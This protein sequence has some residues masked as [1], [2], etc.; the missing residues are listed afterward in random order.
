[1]NGS[2]RWRGSDGPRPH[3]TA[4][5]LVMRSPFRFG[6][7]A[8]L[9]GAVV[10]AAALLLPVLSTVLVMFLVAWLLA[11]G[12]NRGVALLVRK[13]LR[14]GL[15]V[16]AVLLGC[17]LAAALLG[18]IVVPVAVTEI[19]GLVG[20]LDDYVRWLAS[21]DAVQDFEERYHL[22][23]QFAGYLT[24]DRVQSLASGVIGG[25]VSV[26]GAF[27][28]VFTV[29]VLTLYF[30]VGYDRILNGA[31][32]LAP[33]SKRA[34]GREL[35]DGVLDKVGGYLTG[36]VLVAICA[37]VSSFLLMLVLGTP[38]P[39]ALALVVAGLDLIPQVGA[40]LGA[41]V[42]A[43]VTLTV[44]L[45]AALVAVAFFIGY[46][47]LENF[48]IYPRVMNRTVQVSSLAAVAS[49]LVGGAVAG[50]LGVLVAVPACAAVQLIVRATVLPRLDRT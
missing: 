17:L 39:L 42:C 16:T 2:R 12:L 15:A 30:L 25:A 6:L 10:V 26:A 1:M 34:D 45:P 5:P 31:F 47:Q 37:G 22:F 36:A 18:A 48:F 14:R 40:T 11:T 19:A 9:G 50:V 13:G 20:S 24:P 29:G 4:P 27:F 41:V 49:V 3:R 35:A 43:L 23:D 8:S 21:T 28:I 38:Y 7:L 32:R 44:S 33:A 46:Q